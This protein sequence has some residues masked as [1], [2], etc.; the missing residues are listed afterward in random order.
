MGIFALI[1]VLLHWTAIGIGYAFH[2]QGDMFYD[3]LYFGAFLH[4][5]PI[6]V[7]FNIMAMFGADYH[8][9]FSGLLIAGI[10][11]AVL[12]Y[13]SL[14]LSVKEHGFNK[15]NLLTALL[16]AAYLCSS[17]YYLFQLNII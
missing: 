17:G 7:I 10:I 14:A 4:V 2:G 16:E 1:I 8:G 3:N 15:T 5:S 9:R 12:K 13:G 6:M 11:L